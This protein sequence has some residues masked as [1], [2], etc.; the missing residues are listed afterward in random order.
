MSDLDA[1]RPFDVRAIVHYDREVATRLRGCQMV[2]EMGLDEAEHRR[3][4]QAMAWFVQTGR[5]DKIAQYP[6]LLVAYLV[7][8]GIFS[9]DAKGYWP[10]VL[11]HL[12]AEH[13]QAE[14]SALGRGF[15]RSLD[16]FGLQSFEYLIAQAGG[17][18]FVSHIL[19]HGGI[20]R[21]SLGD[22]YLVLDSE[23]RLGR[24]D[25]FDIVARWRGHAMTFCNIDKP[26]ERFLLWGGR[27][28][29]DVLGRCIEL[30]DSSAASGSIADRA[31]S[32]GLP[33]Y[34]VT[35]YDQFR[36][37][38]PAGPGRRGG[39]ALGSRAT[40]VPR[41]DVEIDPW[42][43]LGPVLRLP[44]VDADHAA[45]VVNAEPSGGSTTLDAYQDQTLTLRVAQQWTINLRAGGEMLRTWIIEGVGHIQ[46]VFFDPANGRLVRDRRDLNLGSVWALTPDNPLSPVTLSNHRTGAP[47]DVVEELPRPTGDWRG[48][49]FAHYDL[50][51]VETLV[52]GGARIEGV[53]RVVQPDDRGRLADHPLA[54]VVTDTGLPVYS[55]LPEVILPPTQALSDGRWRVRFGAGAQD[56][57]VGVVKADELQ[58]ALADRRDDEGLVGEYEL[59]IR[60]ALGRDFSE[61]FAVVP[62]LSVSVPTAVCLPG[63]A[64]P[65]VGINVGDGVLVDGQRGERRPV[66][67]RSGAH[68]DAHCRVSDG[69]STVELRIAVPRLAWAATAVAEARRFGIE[70]V[71]FDLA[72]M[73]VGAGSN[74]MVMTGRPGTRLVLRLFDGH[75]SMLQESAPVPSGGQA[76]RWTFGLAE[77]NDT[78][79][80]SGESRLG[81][82]LVVDGRPVWVGS[83]FAQYLVSDIEVISRVIDDFTSVHVAFGESAVL[84]DRKLLF[85]SVDRPWEDAVESPIEDGV[86][87]SVEFAGYGVL[88]VGRYRL[89][90][91]VDD[92]W[93]A[94]SRPAID[95][96][97]CR[98]VRIG[99]PEQITR[100]LS[101]LDEHFPLEWLELA[102]CG[103]L[104][105]TPAPDLA[106][107]AAQLVIV[108]AEVLRTTKIGDR[109]P[110]WSQPISR[111]LVVAGER[112]ISCV[113]AAVADRSIDGRLVSR[114]MLFRLR[115]I[116]DVG[117]KLAAVGLVLDDEVMRD[118]WRICPAWAA[119]VDMP[120]C[121]RREAWSRC[122]QFLGWEP[123]GEIPL[124]PAIKSVE[125]ARS[126]EQ[127]RQ[128]K[129]LMDLVPQ[130][131]LQRD[132]LVSAY[133]EGLI[134]DSAPRGFALEDWCTRNRQM[135]VAA[136]TASTGRF[137]EHL[138]S[139]APLK[140]ALPAAWLP[141]VTLATAVI[142]L[143]DGRR[144][145]E[146]HSAV[147]T[148]DEALA[149]APTL[150]A[151]DLVV[152]YLLHLEA[153]DTRAC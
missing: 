152:A 52:T 9:F 14:Q 26:V 141:A 119:F 126:P 5:R 93:G 75:D 11:E 86:T 42:D 44:A 79:R 23:L 53:V 39:R 151:H 73:D 89:Q 78:A 88:P 106:L 96:K 91:V 28:A 87:G 46:A 116:L 22:F 142:A 129:L 102:V 128:I 63:D 4:S 147:S 100:R 98:D 112:G 30:T 6:A 68:S 103:R 3:L 13:T 144:D 35:E 2:F 36:R 131:L 29:H 107:P 77:F 66:L 104:W 127:L 45:W 18:R 70:P 135:V 74:L 40:Y 148:L 143:D 136:E 51:G 32:V 54:A 120:Q 90:F 117:R 25:A 138:D 95:A 55:R 17:L 31:G 71:R 149:F 41:P 49:T 50:T 57:L 20:P 27:L 69:S 84:R 33:E 94:I 80:A 76:G 61:R 122:T 101:D 81:L 21:R 134:A 92:G 48:Y 124:G 118:L 105:D 114:L 110:V 34:F 123:G 59:S 38:H 67:I 15:E 115:A 8:E 43:T 47:L 133:F 130:G 153:G 60:G 7:S 139:R 58:R 146:R 125:A 65:S 24:G 10:H 37:A 121:H 145:D 132:T 99:T 150:V 56:I 111:M 62:G 140:G 19:I 64:P 113:C 1:G 12:G 108:L 137:A 85:W 16:E 97:N 83:I 109:F 72:D 82:Q